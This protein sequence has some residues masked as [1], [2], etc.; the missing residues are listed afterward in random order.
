MPIRRYDFNTADGDTQFLG[1]Y[2][3]GRRVASR[4][5]LDLYWLNLDRTATGEHHHTIG[6]R[7]GNATENSSVDYDV[8]ASYQFGSVGE[9]DIRAFMLAHQVGYAIPAPTR[10]RVYA[11]FDYASGD[12]DPTDG[13]KGTFNQLFPLAHKYLGFIDLV[14]RQNIVAVSGGVSFTPARKLG[15][16]VS[17]HHFSRA[18]STDALYNAGARIVRPGERHREIGRL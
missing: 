7:V 15:V 12:A 16:A 4:V 17:G 8:E 10:P 6:G 5:E 3:S 2:A 1:I 14:G 13:T 11:G 18:K 9:H